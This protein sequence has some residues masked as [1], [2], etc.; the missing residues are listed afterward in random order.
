MRNREGKGEGSKEKEKRKKLKKRKKEKE[1][2]TKKIL[3][4]F[5]RWQPFYFTWFNSSK[6]TTCGLETQ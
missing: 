4:L 6:I 2:E 3:L 1:G 5:V